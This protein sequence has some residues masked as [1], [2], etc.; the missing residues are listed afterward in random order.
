MSSRL[1]VYP[2]HININDPFLKSLSFYSHPHN[3]CINVKQWT[4]IRGHR[5]K[6]NSLLEELSFSSCTFSP[7]LSP[8]VLC[9]YLSLLNERA[10]PVYEPES[11][12]GGS[13]ISVRWQ[14][15]QVNNTIIKTLSYSSK[16]N[17]IIMR[18]SIAAGSGS[19]VI[20]LKK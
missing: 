1:K 8:S 3:N 11:R 18:C 2:L 16:P 7:A 15:Q 9:A 17:K 6:V 12:C 19:L 13:I 4:N 20:L 10:P 14:F 5:D